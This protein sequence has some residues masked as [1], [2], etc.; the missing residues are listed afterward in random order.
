MGHSGGSFCPAFTFMSLTDHPFSRNVRRRLAAVAVLSVMNAGFTGCALPPPPPPD[1]AYT[2][3]F[4]AN[5]NINDLENVQEY[6]VNVKGDKAK[7]QAVFLSFFFFDVSQYDIGQYPT[8]V[9]KMISKEQSAYLRR[10]FFYSIDSERAG[11]CK[12]CARIKAKASLIR[13]SDGEIIFEQVLENP[14]SFHTS[15]WGK[16]V[17]LFEILLEPGRY[18]MKFKLDKT[19]HRLASMVTKIGMEGAHHGK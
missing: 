8:N 14:R 9:Y 1:P 11:M 17:F 19:D 18:F 16:K 10:E 6:E 5:L 4:V 7:K 12:G 13:K 15:M 2:P 3:P